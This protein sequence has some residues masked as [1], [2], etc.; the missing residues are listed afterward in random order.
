[1]ALGDGGRPLLARAARSAPWRMGGTAA[2]LERRASPVR[3][4]PIERQ[5]LWKQGCVQT[6]CLQNGGEGFLSSEGGAFRFFI[7]FF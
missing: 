3:A 7:F 2:V 6:E 5:P 1:M 4:V